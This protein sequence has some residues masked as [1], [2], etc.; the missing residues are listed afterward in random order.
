MRTLVIPDLHHNVHWVK[1]FL[2]AQ[3]Y[4]EVV[5][6]GDYFDD[7][8]DS[9]IKAKETAYWLKDALTWPDTIFLLGNHDIAYRFPINGYMVCAGF[10]EKKS[11]EINRILSFD[12]WAKIGLCYYTQGFLC[13][14]AGI[15]NH[16]FSN[17]P[18]ISDIEM[19]C[20]RSLEYA[21][22]GNTTNILGCGY[23]RG[24]NQPIGGITWCDWEQEF[25]PLPGISQI[26]GHTPGIGI[27]SKNKTN[28]KN[29]CIDCMSRKV[30]VIED[31]KFSEIDSGIL[32]PLG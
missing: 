9:P 29:Y 13:S 14:H 6:L 19:L 10:T 18:E 11:N 24:G 5:F 4:T 2:K 12:D 17:M 3:D 20:N 31:G 30:G 22:C 26:V 23:G 32:P 16:L 15:A 25:N 8:N 7:W 27:R 28:S 21:Q 1:D